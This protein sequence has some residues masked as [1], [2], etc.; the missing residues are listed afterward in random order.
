M[1]INI[2]N[3]TNNNGW[4]LGNNILTNISHINI[5]IINNKIEL[6]TDVSD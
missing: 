6:V 5:N 2:I 4:P 3:I 1:I